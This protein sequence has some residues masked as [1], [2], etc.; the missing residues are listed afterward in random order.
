MGGVA[1]APGGGKSPVRTRRAPEKNGCGPKP[2]PPMFE[3]GKEKPL[4]WSSGGTQ[5]KMSP[6]TYELNGLQPHEK[7]R[8]TRED[9]AARTWETSRGEGKTR[10]WEKQGGGDGILKTSTCCREKVFYWRGGGRG[11][12][13]GRPFWWDDDRNKKIGQSGGETR[14]ETI[15]VKNWRPV[16][17][18][19]NACGHC[20]QTPTE[21]QS[22]AKSTQKKSTTNLQCGENG[23]F[24][25]LKG[26]AGGETGVWAGVIQRHPKSKREKRPGDGGHL[27][28]CQSKPGKNVS[29]TRNRNKSPQLKMD[30]PDQP[31]KVGNSRRSQREATGCKGGKVE[32]KKETYLGVVWGRGVKAI[33]P[34][35]NRTHSLVGR[36]KK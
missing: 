2:A 21:T 12:R 3:G 19:H 4:S 18:P 28:R 31:E 14:R 1:A 16:S 26:D 6:E 11:S 7:Q 32:K 20:L 13:Q 8:D 25:K 9:D 33:G 29:S 34:K 5:R 24:L 36:A 27:D 30:G 35:N 15:R 10:N 22:R 23:G 17:S